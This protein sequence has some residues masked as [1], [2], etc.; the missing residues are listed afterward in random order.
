MSAITIGP[1]TVVSGTIGTTATVVLNQNTVRQFFKIVNESPSAYICYTSDALGNGSGTPPAGGPFAGLPNT[2]GTTP[3]IN[4]AG[5]TL[6][7]G[8]SE[9]CD[10]QVPTGAITLIGSAAGTPYTIE[11]A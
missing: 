4:G 5:T 3:V 1:R 2:A 6:L 10:I 9:T 8:G 7:P 11:W